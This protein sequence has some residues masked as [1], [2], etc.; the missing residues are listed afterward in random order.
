[1]P[2]SKQQALKA[3]ASVLLAAVWCVFIFYMS[4]K[5][6]DSSQQMSNGVIKM[7]AGVLVPGY[8]DMDTIHQAIAVSTLSFPVRK[9][10]H[11]CEYAILGLLVSNAALQIA[12]TFKQRGMDIAVDT[13]P[14]VPGRALF[15]A[16]WAFCALFAAGDEFHQLFVDGR[17]GQLF[18]VGVDSVGALAGVLVFARLLVKR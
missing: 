6:G 5:N 11:F 16:A 14:F 10:A 9:A 12:R 4:A 3:A 17:S 15:A 2:S 1:M 8:A 13:V 7:L 18:D